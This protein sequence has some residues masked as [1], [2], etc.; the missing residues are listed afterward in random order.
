[1]IKAEIELLAPA[2]KWDVMVAAVAAGADAVYLG[3]K[4]FNMR[5]LRPEYNFSDSELRDACEYLHQ[6]SK[7]LYITVNNL[8]YQAELEEL[9][10]YLVFIND[11]GADAV[12]IQDLAIAQLHKELNL[13]IPIHAS[14]QMG[15]ANG[16]AAALLE[17]WGFSRAILSKNLS[18][19]EIK[20]IHHSTRLSIEY[21]AH[22]DL[23]V[24]HAGQCYMSSFMAGESGNRGRCLKPCRWPYSVANGIPAGEMKYYLAHNDLCLVNHIQDLIEA[25][26]ASFK[27]E[28][29]MRGAEYIAHLITCYREA[30]DN[31]INKQGEGALAA[32]SRLEE[33]KIRDFCTGNLYG[34]PEIDA[35]GLSGAR[36][37]VF[38]STALR[39]ERLKTDDFEHRP[40]TLEKSGQLSVKLHDPRVIPELLSPELETVIMEWEGI[41]Q[42]KGQKSFGR[43]QEA[44]RQLEGL[45]TGLVVELPRIVAQNDLPDIRIALE[46]IRGINVLAVMVN[47]YGSLKLARD[48]GYNIW[49]GYGLNLS[50]TAAAGFLLNNGLKRLTISP[51][52][53]AGRI[54]DILNCQSPVEL[55]MMVHGPCAV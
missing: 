2:G 6:R 13:Q 4:R 49:G 35:I 15:I 42:L 30:L 18:L 5:M 48:Y 51:E 54:K 27:I 19:Q 40:I 14:V 47:D 33:N 12:I 1:M 29:R 16:A 26:V 53:D 8:Y 39:L 9:Q 20:D 55:E 34:R 7:K 23:C 38:I 37:P 41:R 22:G 24:S 3:G 10:D 44:A 36:E 45:N 31:A 28:G 32:H 46:N 11:I 17:E 21:F 50:N 52:L 25:G 43:I